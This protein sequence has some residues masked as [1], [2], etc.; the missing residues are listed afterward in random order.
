M[1]SLGD[2]NNIYTIAAIWIGLAFVASLI[3]IRFGL[4]VALAEILLGVFGGNV[5]HISANTWIDFLASFGSVLL[6]F[7][8]GAE[9][10]P[11]SLRRFLVPSLGIGGVGFAAP[12]AG[13]WAFA[14]L[15]LHWHWQ[16]SQ[17]AG[18]ALSTTS[19]AVVYAVM[20][21]TGLN[22]TDLG[23]LILTA[24]F[25]CDLGTVL[26]LGILFANY[27][28]LLIGF[29]I[30]TAV[31]LVLLPWSLRLIIRTLGHA[32]SEPE[33]K[34]VFLLLLALGGL[35]AAARS[36][37]VLPAYLL[38]LVAAGTFQADP[39]LAGRIRGTAFSF[40]T[41]FF[42]LKAGTLI[43]ASS[44]LNGIAAVAVL[45]GVKM[46]TKV[47]SV[48]PATRAFRIL[49]RQ[50]W[51]TTMMMSTGLTFGSISALFGLTHGYID[52]DQYSILVTVVVLTALIPTLI[53]Q[54]AFYPRTTSLAWK[55]TDDSKAAT[56]EVAE[57][58]A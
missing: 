19:V 23:K 27:N 1:A 5:L 54:V 39:R 49:G 2:F 33:V 17:V 45:F 6:T 51:Y 44:V 14:F 4:S 30:A 40:L 53:A 34:Y 3:S 21:E 42:F 46:V 15:I 38:G 55:A 48:F 31:A 7:L 25:V 50:A 35:A 43:V 8:A 16:A 57:P 18:V 47:I 56:V 11:K 41:P 24:C 26:S 52:R 32:V 28:A 29:G 20:V 13:A 9:I 10:D 36:E 37:A 22:K 58:N 12:F